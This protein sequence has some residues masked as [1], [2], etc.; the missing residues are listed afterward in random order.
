MS[1]SA[2]ALRSTDDRWSVVA[3]AEA[4]GCGVTS[5]RLFLI[6]LSPLRI[7]EDQY[8]NIGGTLY[9]VW[10]EFASLRSRVRKRQGDGPFKV[11]HIVPICSR[12]NFDSDLAEVRRLI[13]GTVAKIGMRPSTERLAR[14]IDHPAKEHLNI[15]ISRDSGGMRLRKQCRPRLAA[16][17]RVSGRNALRPATPSCVTLFDGLLVEFGSARLTPVREDDAAEPAGHGNVVVQQAWPGANVLSR[18]S[19]RCADRERRA[20]V[21]CRRFVGRARRGAGARKRP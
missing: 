5:Q 10:T 4:V 18:Y 3:R 14:G 13:K 1:G 7:D 8:Q 11:K 17:V 2:T 16:S 15:R 21:F 19:R 20:H 9:W 6:G 12:F